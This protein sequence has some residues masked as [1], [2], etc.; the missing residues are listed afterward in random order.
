M[1]ARIQNP[2]MTIPG[3]FDALQA[4]EATTKVEG[5]SQEIREL[6]AIRASQINGCSVCLDMHIR[7]AR[8]GGESDERL[9]TLA[10]WRDAPYFT[11]AERAALA[12]AEA[13]TRLSDRADAVP[14]DIWSDAAKYFDEP[15]LAALV[16]IIASINL[17]NRMNIAT[18]QI[19]GEWTAQFV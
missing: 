6:V 11:E 5:L 9:S 2:V 18:G 15:A 12:L 3:L 8:K 10:A 4:L 1:G 16:V 13:A 14:D 17:W 19:A 7:G